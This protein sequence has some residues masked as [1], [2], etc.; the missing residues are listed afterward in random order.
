MQM[1]RNPAAFCLAALLLAL[2]VFS[3]SCGKAKTADDETTAVTADTAARTEPV[4]TE[5]QYV[6]DSLPED[7]DFGGVKFSILGWEG[8]GDAE[9]IVEEQNGDVVNDAKYDHY[10]EVEERLNITF[11]ISV[12]PGA[13][14]DRAAWVKGVQSSVLAGNAAYDIVSGYSMSGASLA[15]NK[16]LLDL[17]T[18]PYL[19]FSKPW[20]P[21][22]LISNATCGGKLYFCSGDISTNMIYMLF[23]NFFNKALIDK[24]GLENPYQVLRDNKWTFDRMTEMISQS[25]SDLN[26]NGEKDIEDAFGFVESITYSDAWFFASGLTTTVFDAEGLPTLSPEFGGE[27][28]HALLEKLNSLFASEYALL[29]DYSYS[30][31]YTIAADIFCGGRS[32]FYCS[33]VWATEKFLRDAEIS[34]GIMPMPK[35]DEA[36]EKFYTISSFP[37]SLYGIPIDAKTPEMSAAVLECLASESY[38]TVSPALFEVAL[39][40]KYSSDEDSAVVYDIIRESN[41][42]DFGRIFNDSMDAMTFNLF[43]NA[44]SN[45]STDWMSIYAKSEKSLTKKLQK[46]VEALIAE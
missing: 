23:L 36:Q 40:V 15:Y 44:V 25:Y 31:T 33:E 1:F 42:F 7:L 6:S 24:Y 46:V 3:A 17:K 41:C 10:R 2:A 16:L 29:L 12:K 34:Y 39:K 37:Y 30:N 35:Y 28:T 14:N 27:K 43:R 13:Y 21:D 20:W 8:S 4:E 32:I 11:D 18:Q 9:F 5:P 38:R 26:G 45:R 19:D 22:S